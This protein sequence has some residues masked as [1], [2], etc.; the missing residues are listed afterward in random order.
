MR[1]IN[2]SEYDV[3]HE[4]VNV[5]S[6]GNN[7]IPNAV[8]LTGYR[9]LVVHFYLI[10]RAGVRVAWQSSAGQLRSGELE[11]SAT[12]GLSAPEAG[13]GWF[14]IPEGLGLMLNLGAA[15]YVGGNVVWTYVPASFFAAGE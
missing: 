15:I 5:S 3:K 1:G 9:I 14:S 12:G 8:G 2:L 4:L 13:Q 11:F 10:G 7:A 6:S